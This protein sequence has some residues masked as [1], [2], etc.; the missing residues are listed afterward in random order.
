MV[1]NRIRDP[2]SQSCK[3][4]LQKSNQLFGVNAFYV[5]AKAN[6]LKSKIERLKLKGI[7]G[8]LERQRS[9]WLNSIIREKAYQNLQVWKKQQVLQ[10]CRQLVF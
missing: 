4:C 9:M 8:S 6:H 5:N 1:A 3:Q 7:G 2:S 10:G